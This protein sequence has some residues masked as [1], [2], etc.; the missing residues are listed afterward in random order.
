MIAGF[1]PAAEQAWKFGQVALLGVALAAPVVAADPTP[2]YNRDIRPILSDNCFA[3]HGPDAGNRQGDLRLDVR[4]DAIA[5]GAIV[6]R[7]PGKSLLITRI[8]AADPDVVMPPPRSHKQLDA[9]Q[10]ETLAQW[11]A[12]GAEYQKHWAYEPPVKP[13]IPPGA[14]AIDHL[15]EATPTSGSWT[16]CSPARTTA[17]GWRSTGSTSSA[18]PTRSATTATTRGRSGRTATG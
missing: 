16:G 13:P 12:A 18:S 9:R 7:D 1:S 6:P 11:I 14:D 4:E 10:K 15:V 5:T 17:N 8:N 2:T 3:C